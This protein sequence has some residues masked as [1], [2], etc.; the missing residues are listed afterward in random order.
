MIYSRWR[1][2]TG[3][4]DLFESSHQVDLGNDLPVPLFAT[5]SPIGISSVEVGRH[6]TGSARPR[7]TSPVPMG[8]ILPTRRASAAL[9]DLVNIGA[10]TPYLPAFVMG[11]LVGWGVCVWISRGGLRAR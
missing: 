2:A 10:Y 1:P 3:G 4:Y 9:G 11:G 8:M 6:L 5:K 7:G